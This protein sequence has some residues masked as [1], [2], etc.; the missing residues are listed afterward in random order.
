MPEM[1]TC[2]RDCDMRQNSRVPENVT[3]PEIVTC[4][5]DSDMR[6]IIHVYQRM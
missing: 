5:R 3:L 2:A 4:A 1:M 6:Q